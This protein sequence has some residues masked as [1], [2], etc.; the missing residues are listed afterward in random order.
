LSKD[1]LEEVTILQEKD[2]LLKEQSLLE[3]CQELEKLPFLKEALQ[4]S[5]KCLLKL[6]QSSE[7][8][9]PIE[10]DF[11]EKKKKHNAKLKAKSA[12]PEGEL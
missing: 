2:L 5:D 9:E 8:K 1:E 6:H 10:E 11:M 4:E 12:T 3:S 7:E